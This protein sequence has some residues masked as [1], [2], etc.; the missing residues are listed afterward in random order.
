MWNKY[1]YQDVHELNLDWLLAKVKALEI[2]QKYINNWKDTIVDPFIDTITN[3]KNNTVDPFISDTTDTL[4]DHEARITQAEQDIVDLDDRLDN[5]EQNITSLADTVGGFDDRI[6]NVEDGLDGL[7]DDVDALESALDG[8]QD[9]LTAGNNITIEGNVI[10]A[11][12]ELSADW[13]DITNRP[14]ESIGSGLEVVNGVLNATGGQGGN[15]AWNDVTNKP[16]STLGNQ[17]TNT[18]DALGVANASPTIAGVIKTYWDSSTNTL[19]ITDNG[20]SPIPV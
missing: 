7:S 6:S 9:A 16:F 19:Y 4:A 14:F 13:D 3:W 10:S 12:G 15:P 20:N 11:T 8:K 1:P 2:W 18:G 17:M 5:A